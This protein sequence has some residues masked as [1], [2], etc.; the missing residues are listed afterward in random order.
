MFLVIASWYNSELE[1]LLSCVNKLETD[2][3]HSENHV[4]IFTWSV[5]NSQVI[6]GLRLMMCIG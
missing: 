6:T 4:G 2:S 1:T 3:S 5:M